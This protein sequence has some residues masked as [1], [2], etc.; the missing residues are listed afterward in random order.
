M[1]KLA[2]V[3][4]GKMGRMIEQ[5]APHFDFEIHSRIDIGGD[6]A[7]VKGADV[8]IEFTE[9]NAVVENVEKLAAL[10]VP[11]VVGTTGWAG[12]MDRVRAAIDKNEGRMIWA[13][14]ISVGVMVFSKLVGEAAQL[15]ANETEYAAWAWEIH[16]SAKKDAQ[17]G[18][19]LKLV[20]DMKRAGYSRPID[21]S[22]NR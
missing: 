13:P 14:N 15:L 5:L 12:Q 17:S 7:A 4:Y 2:I 18:T 22:S 19:L 1:N 11:I 16:H 20:D 3:G 10:R 21:A 9:P 6:F 8:A